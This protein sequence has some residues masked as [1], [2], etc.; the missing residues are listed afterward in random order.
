MRKH[1]SLLDS[2]VTTFWP[3]INKA[4]I[5]LTQCHARVIHQQ[6]HNKSSFHHND[7]RTVLDGEFWGSNNF[8]GR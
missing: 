8:C 3:S 5:M 4:N 1:D 6:Y 7:D 2:D